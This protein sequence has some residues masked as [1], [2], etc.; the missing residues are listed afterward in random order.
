M[1]CF[2]FSYIFLSCV[3]NG[4]N[5]NPIERIWK[6][7]LRRN[8]DIDNQ[9]N[10]HFIDGVASILSFSHLYNDLL[11][12][13]HSPLANKEHFLIKLPTFDAFSFVVYRDV[14]NSVRSVS[15]ICESHLM[16]QLMNG[17]R[18]TDTSIYDKLRK[19]II[20]IFCIE[21]R[22]NFFYIL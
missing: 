19:V 16:A 11:V 18:F 1:G 20:A 13:I 10:S 12:V 5:E 22:N 7:F 3:V 14:M 15:Q 17:S 8:A 9:L 21:F 2:C 6:T 4:L